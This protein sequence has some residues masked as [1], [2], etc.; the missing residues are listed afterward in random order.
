[1]KTLGMPEVLA[2]KGWVDVD[3]D[4]PERDRADYAALA[5]TVIGIAL[6][7]E[8]IREALSLDLQEGTETGPVRT[9][10]FGVGSS[11]NS[12]DAKVYLHAGY[13]SRAHA[14]LLVP[15]LVQPSELLAFWAIHDD[16]LHAIERFG[17]KAL[18]ELGAGPVASAIFSDEH[19]LRNIHVRTVRY[20]GAIKDP[21]GKEVV[22]G[23]ADLGLAT[24]HVY[25]TH[26]GWLRAAPYDHQVMFADDTADRREAVRR[27]RQ[28][29]EMI[30][31][32]IDTSATFFLGG[33]WHQFSGVPESLRDLP[34]LYHAG[35]RADPHQ[36]TVSIYAPEVSDADD[37]VS[38]IA[39]MNANLG[40]LRDGTYRPPTVSNCRPE[41]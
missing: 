10:T 6:E 11:R 16:M 20:E 22:S 12:T 17:T 19:R 33:S 1:M 5:N 21:V 15:E 7:N 29:L 14:D 18:Q 30:D 9:S 40:L 38:L 23:H 32:N 39:F 24:L 25:E 27:K 4:V 8:A 2:D 28:D 31:Q 35:F 26:G 3:F 37:R 41:Y 36:E 13:Q 34:A